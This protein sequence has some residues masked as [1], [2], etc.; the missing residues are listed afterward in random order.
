MKSEAAGHMH[1]ESLHNIFE[2]ECWGH[3]LF[4]A[5]WVKNDVGRKVGPIWEQDTQFDESKKLSN[6]FN[7]L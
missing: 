1:K 2:Y 3:P 7:F 4:S 6:F 5:E